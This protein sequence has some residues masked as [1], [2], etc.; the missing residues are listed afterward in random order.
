MAPTVME[1]KTGGGKA[2][3][4]TVK[5]EKPVRKLLQ[6][7]RRLL[8]CITVARTMNT[9]MWRSG[10]VQNTFQKQANGICWWIRNRWEGWNQSWLFWP[11]QLA[12]MPIAEIENPG[13]ENGSGGEGRGK[14]PKFYWICLLD[15]RWDMFKSGVDVQ[16]CNGKEK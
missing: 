4:V 1:I 8:A 16:G 7:S 13:W 9:K 10:W 14:K 11:E 15:I 3:E 6:E 5:A 12:R 2:W